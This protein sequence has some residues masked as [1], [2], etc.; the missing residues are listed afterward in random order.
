MLQDELLNIPSF[1]VNPRRMYSVGYGIYLVCVCV[2][3]VPSLHADKS[4]YQLN[5]H[6][7]WHYAKIERCTSYI[8]L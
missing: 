8:F 6:T 7:D 5:G 4:I 2:C 3:Q 1:V